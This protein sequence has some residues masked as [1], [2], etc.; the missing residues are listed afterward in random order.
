MPDVNTEGMAI[1]G[2]ARWIS[3]KVRPAIEAV[4][5]RH[6]LDT[7][8]FDVL[9]T[10]L[11][12]GLPY[13]LR[14]I[15]LY[16]SLMISPGGLTARLNRL[17]KAELIRRVPLEEDGRSMP[18]ELT[19]EGKRR[20]EQAFREDMIVETQLLA[21]LTAKERKELAALLKKLA[22]SVN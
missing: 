5:T 1:L 2:R 10:L 20:A 11:R 13:R 17:E 18:V 16:R 6:S 7:G 15:E 8:E 4:F 19:A 3:L 12:S 14:P 9:G 22:L 21:A